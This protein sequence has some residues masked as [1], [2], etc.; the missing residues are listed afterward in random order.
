MRRLYLKIYLTI[1]VSLLLV[2]VVAGAV[3]R[4]GWDQSP[5]GQAFEMAGELVAAVLPPADAPRSVQ[6]QAIVQLAQRLGTDLAL[7]DASLALVASAGGPLPPPGRDRGGWI[8]G[9]LGPA[10]SFRL[11]DGRAVVARAPARHRHPAVALMLFLGGI[12]LA[13]A[14]CAY[15]VVRGLTRRLERLQVAVETLGAGELS[16]RVEVAGRDEVA[17]LAAAFNRAA[18]RIEELVNAHRMLLSNASHEFRTPLSRIRLGIE[19]FQQNADPKY[20]AG[21]ARDIAELDLLIDEILLASRLDATRA[22]PAT[23]D[24]D[25]L[26]LVAEECA[27]YDVM[28]DGAA[29]TV[30]GD[31]RLLRRLT[32][33]LLENARRHGKPP[34]RVAVRAEN[35]RE[36]DPEKWE[37]VFRKDH[38]PTRKRR[39]AGDSVDANRTLAVLEVMDAG[40]GVPEVERERVFEPF[41]RLGTDA[42]GAGL[43]LALVR[44]IAR[45]HG[46][47]AVVAPRT[48]AP[49][50]FRVTLPGRGQVAPSP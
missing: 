28:P 48:D 34:L 3:W 20:Q 32:R 2:V 5:A 4:S 19:L 1:I 22:L 11:P 42:A 33:N 6:Q 7:Y 31:P 10:W 44:Q 29:V 23:E 13:V 39:S 18:A 27:H 14:A 17:R 24:V 41:H 37:P 46:G 50:C 49:S 21:I 26:A 30:R 35:A 38:A 8:Y 25:L 40:A 36:H 16:A 47:D 12:A 15:P 9:P 45:L 43:G